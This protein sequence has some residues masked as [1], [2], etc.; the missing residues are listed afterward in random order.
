MTDRQPVPG[1]HENFAESLAPFSPAVDSEPIGWWYQDSTGC[2]HMSLD[3]DL[4]HRHERETG[5]ALN[6]MYG[7]PLPSQPFG[8]APP[9]QSHRRGIYIASKTK[10]ADR[11]R[12]LREAGF[13]IIST[14]IDEAGAGESGDLSDLWRRCILE[15]STAS[16]LVLYREPADVLKGGWVELGAALACGVPVFAVGIEEFTIAKNKRI[17]HFATLHAALAA[18]ATEGSAE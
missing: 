3:M 9:P 17:R 15:A 18:T 8:T 10:H 13:P 1:V 16:A 7:K 4:G 6:L 14:W 2:I 5:H 11:W 12:R